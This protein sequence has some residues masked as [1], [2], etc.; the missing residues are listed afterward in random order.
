MTLSATAEFGKMKLE[1]WRVL[2][3]EVNR[4]RRGDAKD[5]MR[6]VRPKYARAAA[7]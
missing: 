6:L 7:T 3:D 4:A 5:E 1:I 2:E